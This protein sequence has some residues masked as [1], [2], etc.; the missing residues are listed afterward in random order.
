M[1]LGIGIDIVKVDRIEKAVER[2]SDSFTKRVFTD[3]ELAYCVKQ[4]RPALHLAARFGAKEAVMKAFGTGHSGGVKWTDVEVLNDEKGKP[5]VTLSGALRDLAAGMGVSE[6]M[7]SMS[8]D[9][10]YAV[11]QAILTGGK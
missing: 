8:H 1:I 6:A 3:R 5:V 9:T 10:A 4:K 2:W 7:I 11:S